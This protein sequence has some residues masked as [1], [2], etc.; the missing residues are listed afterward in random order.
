ME[1]EESNLI[2]HVRAHYSCVLC[3]LSHV[4]CSVTPWTVDHQA[5]LSTEFSRQEYWS[6]LLFPPQMIFPTQRLNPHLLQLVGG[7]FNTAPLGKPH[8]L[9]TFPW[10]PKAFGGKEKASLDFLYPSLGDIFPPSPTP[11]ANTVWIF[12]W[13]SSYPTLSTCSLGPADSTGPFQP[14]APSLSDWLTG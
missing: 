12:T 7:F 1:T 4:W 5:P 11:S 10:K 9:I 8:V 3:L 2:S 14:E 6:G 13:G